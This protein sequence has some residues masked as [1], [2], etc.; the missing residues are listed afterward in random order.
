MNKKT[1]LI[2]ILSLVMLMLVGCGQKQHIPAETPKSDQ[3]EVQ[4]SNIVT[5]SH[6]AFSPEE[7]VIKKGWTVTWSNLDSA[8]HTVT[9]DTGSELASGTLTTGDSY[10]HTFNSAGRFTYHCSLHSMMVGVIVVK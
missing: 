10:S 7:F 2:L 5:I 1:M 8:S 4:S 6:F 3:A 9:S